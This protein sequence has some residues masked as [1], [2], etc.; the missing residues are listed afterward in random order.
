MTLIKA[1]IEQTVLKVRLGVNDAVAAGK[2][3]PLL[4]QQP[5]VLVTAVAAL[6][7]LAANSAVPDATRVATGDVGHFPGVAKVVFIRGRSAVG[8]L[9]VVVRVAVGVAAKTA[10]GAGVSGGEDEAGVAVPIEG[11]D[12]A[13]VG[14]EEG[15]DA[16]G[17]GVKLGAVAEGEV[18][19][20][21]VDLEGRR[22]R[23]RMSKGG[24]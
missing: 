1:G 21:A 6:L 23:E 8:G 9:E 14:L 7:R 2:G 16:A 24:L 10:D 13:E 22:R 19:Q 4:H 12:E 5:A 15:V 18:D 17:V 11:D 3:P 20:E